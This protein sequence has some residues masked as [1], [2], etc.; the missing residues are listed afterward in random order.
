MYN[1]IYIK[2]RLFSKG[3]YFNEELPFWGDTGTQPSRVQ[4]CFL[5][6]DLDKETKQRTSH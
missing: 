1:A 6:G 3:D 5:R 2:I 4:L